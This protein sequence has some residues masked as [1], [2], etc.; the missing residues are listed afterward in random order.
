MSLNEQI[1]KDF[2]QALKNKKEAELLSLRML[3]NAIKNATIQKK[4]ELKDDEII[5]LIR[6]EVKKRNESIEAF[7]KGDRDDLVTKEKAELEILKIYLPKEL[8]DEKIK[9]I[10]FEVIESSKAT[11]P[12]DFGKV[13][14][15][16]MKKTGGQVEGNKVSQLVKE[17]LQPKE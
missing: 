6:S 14:G 16:V 2:I 10:I 12:Q 1:E 4:A 13:M 7:M 5:K 3:K 11:G 17:V 15:L 9:K 8:G